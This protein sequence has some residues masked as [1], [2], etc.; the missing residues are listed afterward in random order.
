MVGAMRWLDAHHQELEG[1]PAYCLNFDGAGAPG[2]LVLLERYGFGRRFSPVMSAAA[3]RA[4][5]RLGLEPRGIL[6]PPGMGIDAIPFAHR[7]IPCLTVSSGSLGRAT[8]AVHSAND[9][10]D[11][12]DAA[13]L[14]TAA[15]LG[16]ETLLELARTP[17]RVSR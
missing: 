2:R 7:G 1:R 10:A 13:T 12:L 8:A 4:A 11:H 6:H 3:R 14:E 15:R 5:T 9:R 17:T 16:L